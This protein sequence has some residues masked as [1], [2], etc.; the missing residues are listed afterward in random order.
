MHCYLTDRD[1]HEIEIVNSKVYRIGV[2]DCV[3]FGVAIHTGDIV[4]VSFDYDHVTRWWTRKR[5]I[6]NRSEWF[7]RLATDEI[8]NLLEPVTDELIDATK[9][10][11]S[12]IIHGG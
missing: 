9:E 1:I 10:L 8:K 6:I 4:L 3:T 2:I 12:H 11:S 7:S 5:M